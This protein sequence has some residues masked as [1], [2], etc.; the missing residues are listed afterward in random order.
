MSGSLSEPFAALAGGASETSRPLTMVEAVAKALAA[1]L[2]PLADGSFLGSE[3]EIS[4]RFGLSKPTLRQAARL[5]EHRELLVVKRGVNGGYYARRPSA[6]AVAAAAAAYLMT[7]GTSH[8][9]II[10]FAQMYNVETARLAAGSRDEALREALASVV[11][12]AD[13]EDP[14][15]QS[16]VAFLSSD[17]ALAGAI[18]ALT[19]N[20]MLGLVHRIAFDVGALQTRNSFAEAPQRRVQ[21]RNARLAVARAVLRGDPE[22]AAAAAEAANSLVTEWLRAPDSAG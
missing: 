11:E 17:D 8:R 3:D 13:G 7:R 12:R 9:Q 18:V 5:L 19:E 21:W 14:E 1:E 20:P 6:N 4:R 22:Q 15:R 2:A 16:A 10:Q